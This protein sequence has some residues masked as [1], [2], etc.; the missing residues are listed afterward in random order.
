MSKM[1]FIE[2]LYAR[3]KDRKSIRT[4]LAAFGVIY[5]STLSTPFELLSEEQVIA[6]L[7]SWTERE[8]RPGEDIRL[9]IIDEQTSG[10]YEVTMRARSGCIYVTD[11]YPTPDLKG[12]QCY[13]WPIDFSLE[14]IARAAIYA[15]LSEAD[16]MLELELSSD[17]EAKPT[18]YVLV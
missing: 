4:I 2:L 11:I 8:L 3:K 7:C 16:D 10:V 14:K 1:S 15:S 9:R 17:E 5:W 13:S 6:L 12:Q 18:R